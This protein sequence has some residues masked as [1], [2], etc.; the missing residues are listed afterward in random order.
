MQ[1]KKNTDKKEKK[2]DSYYCIFYLQKVF[3]VFSAC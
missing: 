2:Q 3:K 1:Q